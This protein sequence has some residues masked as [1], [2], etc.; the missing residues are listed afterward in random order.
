MQIKAASEIATTSVVVTV[1]FP[2]LKPS[3]NGFI[4]LVPSN[5]VVPET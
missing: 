1:S 4:S 5:I 3:N 2:P